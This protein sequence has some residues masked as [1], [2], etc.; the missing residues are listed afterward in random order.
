MCNDTQTTEKK[1]KTLTQA[2]EITRVIQWH[3]EGTQE[4]KFIPCKKRCW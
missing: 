1:K 3:N 2:L 4:P